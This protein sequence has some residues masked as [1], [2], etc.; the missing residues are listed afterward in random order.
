MLTE[1]GVVLVKYFLHITKKQ[2]R[3]RLKQLRSNPQT[4]WRVTKDDELYVTNYKPLTKSV[5]QTLRLTSPG[6]APWIVVEAADRRY[7]ELAVAQSLLSAMRS[8]LDASRA[9]STSRAVNLSVVPP[10]RRSIL[11]HT[12]SYELRDLTSRLP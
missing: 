10:D 2:L 12:R 9:S 6:H 3:Q 7:R 8:R 1:E 4:S 11:S 5:E